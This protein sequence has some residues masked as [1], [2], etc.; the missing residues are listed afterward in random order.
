[1][2]KRGVAGNIRGARKAH[3]KDASGLADQAD[4]KKEHDMRG[5]KHQDIETLRQGK[6]SGKQVLYIWDR[7]GINARQWQRWKQRGGNYFNSRAKENMCLEP[8]AERPL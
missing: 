2:E 5:L 4:R 6:P 1:M 8:I 7:A 3:R